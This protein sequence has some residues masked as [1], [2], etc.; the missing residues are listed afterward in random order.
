MGEGQF[1]EGRA[2]GIGLP[3]IQHAVITQSNTGGGECVGRRLSSEL[4]G[5]FQYMIV[6]RKKLH[7]N[8]LTI[9]NHSNV[10]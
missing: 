2:C 4:K 8:K 7:I 5:K 1:L 3:C 10:T 9:V 6:G